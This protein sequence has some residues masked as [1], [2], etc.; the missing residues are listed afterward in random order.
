M[1]ANVLVLWHKSIQI[2]LVL[3]VPQSW[4]WLPLWLL[5][6]DILLGYLLSGLLYS[7][8]YSLRIGRLCRNSIVLKGGI[9][10]SPIL[11]RS[12]LLVLLSNDIAGIPY[13]RNVLPYFGSL[14]RFYLI[15]CL[16]ILS[17]HFR[18]NLTPVEKL[19]I[20]SK[21]RILR[22]WVFSLKHLV[23]LVWS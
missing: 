3:L 4:P 13:C 6:R 16:L 14:S 22:D 9:I 21:F 23:Y 5:Y 20:L 17:L 11:T 18:N 1:L 7:R 10:E 12:L 15:L 2:L 8:H 19:F